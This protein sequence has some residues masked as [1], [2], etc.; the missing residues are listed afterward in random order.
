M[1]KRVKKDNSYTVQHRM[2]VEMIDA[3]FKLAEKLGAHPLTKGCNCIGCVN[4]RKRILQPSE[5]NWKFKL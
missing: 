5:K 2:I 3:G 4:K 1:K